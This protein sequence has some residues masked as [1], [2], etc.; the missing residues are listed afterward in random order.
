MSL[1]NKS[2]SPTNTTSQTLDQTISTVD[3]RVSEAGAA[4]GGNVTLGPGDIAGQVN[5]S[6][7]DQGTVLAAKDVILESLKGITGAAESQQN[8][9]KNT[10]TEAFSLANAAR[11]SETSGAINNFLKYGVWVALAG[12]A[13]YGFV[14]T[15]K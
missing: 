1:G 2:S 12:I 3:N 5:I 8:A 11:Q 13:V 10:I 9:S 15:K 7:T 4:V 14:A 6:T